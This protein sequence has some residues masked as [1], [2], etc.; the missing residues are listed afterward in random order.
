MPTLQRLWRGFS[1]VM[2]TVG[3]FQ[4]RLLLTVFY[5]V[6]AAP[7]GLG[8]RFSSDP[9]HLR[10]QRGAARWHVREPRASTLDAARRQY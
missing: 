1:R 2:E 10:W 7:F 9:L 6:V 3:N 4:A 8:V 5:L